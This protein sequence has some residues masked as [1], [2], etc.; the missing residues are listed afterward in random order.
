MNRIDESTATDALAVADVIVLIPSGLLRFTG[1]IRTVDI[2]AET[3]GEALRMV[4]EKF[5]LLRTQMF[6]PDER[7]RG[8]INI[9][10]NSKDIRFLQQEQTLLRTQD[11]ITILPA[12]AGG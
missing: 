6:S 8:F 11:V 9:F 1:Q 3:V 5:P 10:L 4:S 12:I 7:L 2:Q